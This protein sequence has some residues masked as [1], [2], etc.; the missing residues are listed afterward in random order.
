MTCFRMHTPTHSTPNADRDPGVATPRG[1]QTRRRIV[2]TRR[3]SINV[4]QKNS[5]PAFQ[6]RPPYLR[7]R[8]R[9]DRCR[10]K[11][12]R[13]PANML[14]N[15]R[16]NFV[17]LGAKL[18][19]SGPNLVDSGSKFGRFRATVGRIWL[20]SGQVVSNSEPSWSKSSR[21]HLVEL[22]RFQTMLFEIGSGSMLAASGEILAQCRRIEPKNQSIPEQVRSIPE[23]SGRCRSNV[24][25][26]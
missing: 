21:E 2:A 11:A 7:I 18:A 5:R 16:P 17:E 13:F 24:S 19:K 23:Q 25:Q 15:F 6:G 20:S 3:C 22:S 1:L 8:A 4:Y 10:A 12:N 26:N 9:I 14:A